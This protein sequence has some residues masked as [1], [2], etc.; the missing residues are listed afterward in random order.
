MREGL[1]CP[2]G[3]R[4]NAKALGITIVGAVGSE[5][6]KNTAS[7]HSP[8]M[9]HYI[10]SPGPAPRRRAPLRRPPRPHESFNLN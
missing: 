2:K 6:L 7:I 3:C 10:P 8:R 5:V 1:G 9:F 4:T